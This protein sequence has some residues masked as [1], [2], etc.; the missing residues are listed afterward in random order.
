MPA[1][2]CHERTSRAVEWIG[3]A[4]G[5]LGPVDQIIYPVRSIVG[6][7]PI[8]VFRNGRPVIYDCISHLIFSNSVHH[9]AR[10]IRPSTMVHMPS[11]CRRSMKCL[12][13]P[14]SSCDVGPQWASCV[15]RL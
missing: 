2:E 6:F 11:V 7:Q 5:L 10:P 9:M 4:I 1:H 15:P 12:Q 13:Y 3:L 8:H 14:V